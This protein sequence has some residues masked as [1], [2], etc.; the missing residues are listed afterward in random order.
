MHQVLSL[1][2]PL[3]MM[4]ATR[5]RD[6]KSPVGVVIAFGDWEML[7]DLRYFCSITG[8]RE[9]HQ[10][11]WI[12]SN[13]GNGKLSCPLT[14]PARHG[15][16][17]GNPGTDQA[18]CDGT[19][20]YAPV[21][22]GR[23]GSLRCGR[24]GS[25]ESGPVHSGPA[26]VFRDDKRAHRAGHHQPFGLQC[27]QRLTDCGHGHPVLLGQASDRRQAV[28]GG[29]LAARDLCPQDRVDLPP[30]GYRTWGDVHD[31]DVNLRHRGDSE[32]SM[33]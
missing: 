29:Q 11:T 8:M 7:P 21:P 16:H 1:C 15:H 31:P 6:D 10:L 25:Q 20:E 30:R 18:A 3:L 12:R 33:R 2:T 24:D 32:G 13:G 27:V 28:A 14:S 17:G 9:Q 22:A 23:G 4:P 19:E 26:L 5:K